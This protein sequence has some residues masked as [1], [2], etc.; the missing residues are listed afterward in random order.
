M[1][2]IV[3]ELMRRVQDDQSSG[4]HLT[5]QVQFFSTTE[6]NGA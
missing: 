5:I 4:V 3:N 1:P 2:R 6:M